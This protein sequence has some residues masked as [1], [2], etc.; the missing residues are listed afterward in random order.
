MRVASPILFFLTFPGLALSAA[1]SS[2]D[3]I[4]TPALR[5]LSSTDPCHRCTERLLPGESQPHPAGR[6]RIDSDLPEIFET[7][8]VLY[9]TR[10]ILPP[11]ETAAGV[12]VPLAQRTQINRQFPGL[13]TGFELYLYHLSQKALPGEI[14]RVVVLMRNLGAEPVRLEAR[15]TILHGPN[16]GVATSVESRLAR[17]VLAESWIRTHGSVEVAPGEAEVVSWSKSLNG[18]TDNDEMSTA[19]F[20]TG[21]V[22]CTI[23]TPGQTPPDVELSVIAIDGRAMDRESM[24]R[25]ALS[26]YGQGAKS[27]ETA[28][29]FL[30]TGTGCE[31]RRVSGVSPWT[32][33]NGHPMHIDVST[34]PTSGGL[35]FK[36]AMFASQSRGCEAARQSVD[37][38][39]YPPYAEPDSVGNYM[40]ETLVSFRL[41]NPT[42]QPRSIDV[43]AGKDDAPIGLAVQ[44]LA[45]P[46]PA[47]RDQLRQQPVHVVWAGPRRSKAGPPY[48]LEYLLGEHPPVQVP[49]HSQI[50]LNLRLMVVGSSSLPY[51][52]VLAPNHQQ[53]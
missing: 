48:H 38:V 45:G 2:Q 5:H 43:L 20:L 27:G 7:T 12:P 22:W 8:G 46:E 32:I 47:S 21:T 52:L 42:N 34:L 41:V 6:F 26:A 3:P 49:P 30:T 1:I 23:E 4:T 17:S 33:W 31:V 9:T 11:F 36:M 53:P 44:V 19:R 14:R 15:D 16:A 35:P 25:A 50:S 40:M 28:I 24:R 10:P 29:D 13:H 39:L 18:P 51:V 37:L